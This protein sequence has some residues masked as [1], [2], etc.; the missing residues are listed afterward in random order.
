[1]TL[2]EDLGMTAE[3]YVRSRWVNVDAP[4]WGIWFG[5]ELKYVRETYDAAAD[6]TA[7]REEQVRLK[8]EEIKLQ[9][10]VLELDWVCLEWLADAE[11]IL[12]MLEAQL[13]ELLNGWKE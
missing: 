13:A 8:R 6:F 2:W 11:R 1:M 12:A 7:A 4:G 10:I 9:K 3:E 5:P